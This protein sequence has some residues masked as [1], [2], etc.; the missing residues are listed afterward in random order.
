MNNPDKGGE[1]GTNADKNTGEVDGR[2]RID[3]TIN[4]DELRQTTEGETI[5]INPGA[6][7]TSS[8]GA[9]QISK[10]IFE[11][12]KSLFHE[13]FIHAELFAQDYVDNNRVDYSNIRSEVKIPGYKSHWHHS[14]VYHNGMN[15]LW[16]GEAYRGLLDVKSQWNM[17]YPD[18]E[19]YRRLWNYNGGKEIK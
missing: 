6:S 12:A 19:M 14:H 18:A 2:L 8:E 11:R 9:K 1:T 17:Q 4:S 13:T 3:V 7:A 5:N 16:P 10:M 15:Q